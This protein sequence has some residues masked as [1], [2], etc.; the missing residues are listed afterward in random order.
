MKWPRWILIIAAVLV[1]AIISYRVARTP[2]FESLKAQGNTLIQQIEAYRAAHG[3]Y[4]D[5]LQQ[6]H[7]KAPH[8]FFGRWEYR[9]FAD[10]FELCL[11]E[12]TRDDFFLRYRPDRGWYLDT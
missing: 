1:T 9:H 4:P 11:G 12:Y 6:A 10:S 2:N 7:I 3:Q 5:S 8:T